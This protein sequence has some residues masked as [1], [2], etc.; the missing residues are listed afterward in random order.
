M[1]K[2]MRTL[3]LVMAAMMVV[4]MIGCG[5]DDD[6]DDDD[7]DGAVE[8][9]F[10]SSNPASGGSIAE[11]G[12]LTIT[13]DAAPVNVTVN[14]V[15][16]VISGKTA[17]FKGPFAASNAVAWENGAGGSAGG[18]TIALTVKAADNTA[19]TVAG[20]G[21]VSDGDADVDPGPI[22]TDAKIEI[23]F[24]EPIT[25][26]SLNLTL[27]DGTSLNWL[28]KIDGDTVVLELT[29]GNDIG[30]ETTYKV[31]GKVSDAAGNET[32]VDITFVT[33]GKE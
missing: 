26:Q 29:K 8:A 25:K 22:N 10:V 32:D 18:A 23:K 27:E 20:G 15:P 6:D 28:S 1:Q 14:G 13:F 2:W 30:N 4:F 17:T 24:S 19:P 21:T 16:A 33:K 12:T 5:D 7:D 9:T 31:A 3:A 11:N